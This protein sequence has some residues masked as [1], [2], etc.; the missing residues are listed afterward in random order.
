MLGD[1]SHHDQVERAGA[2]WQA[3]RKG[4]ASPEHGKLRQLATSLGHHG[5]TLIDRGD[6]SSSLGE[7]ECVPA[8]AAAQ[9]EDR[10]P[11]EWA[12]KVPDGI[13]FQR[14]ERIAVVVVA[15]GPRGVT[16]QRRKL[17]R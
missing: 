2:E 9:V 17:D 8:R 10:F 12:D 5:H 1:Q 16:L 3:S 6:P 15:R 11:L 7:R 4:Q 13:A 14:N